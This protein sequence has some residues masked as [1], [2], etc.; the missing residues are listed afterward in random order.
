MKPDIDL[1]DLD[2]SDLIPPVPEKD[3]VKGWISIGFCGE[4][5]KDAQALQ[6]GGRSP[7]HTESRTP[8][9]QNGTVAK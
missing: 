5:C 9:C 1:F 4:C 8:L 3:A 6:P 7:R 2:I